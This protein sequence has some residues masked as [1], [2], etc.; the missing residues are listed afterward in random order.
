MDLCRSHHRCHQPRTPIVQL[1]IFSILLRQLQ[2]E[3]HMRISLRCAVFEHIQEL[4]TQISFILPKLDSDSSYPPIVDESTIELRHSSASNITALQFFIGRDFQ[5][6]FLPLYSSVGCVADQRPLNLFFQ[7]LA[8]CSDDYPP[9][10]LV[11][12]ANAALLLD[13]TTHLY[14]K[15]VAQVISLEM[16][17]APLYPSQLTTPPVRRYRS[18]ET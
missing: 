6:D 16:R 3:R 2:D 13:H 15:Y 10:E 1:P 9:S 11:G 7:T 5:N 12:P 18:P 4:Q 17:T 14:R 8:P